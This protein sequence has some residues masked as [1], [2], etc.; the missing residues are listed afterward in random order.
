MHLLVTGGFKK[1]RFPM[2]SKGKR[3]EGCM[4]PYAI[5]WSAFLIWEWLES[6]PQLAW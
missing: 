3:W 6:P 4:E 1:G 5:S 2:P